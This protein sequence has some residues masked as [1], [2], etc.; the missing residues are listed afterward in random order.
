M[1]VSGTIK[2]VPFQNHIPPLPHRFGLAADVGVPEI[3]S[4]DMMGM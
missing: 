4:H 2:I 3:L 1:R